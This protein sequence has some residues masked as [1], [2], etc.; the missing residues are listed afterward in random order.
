[1]TYSSVNLHFASI[2]HWRQTATEL[3]CLLQP[4]CHVADNTQSFIS[5]LH[6][7]KWKI[8]LN[9]FNV[10]PKHI[11]IKYILKVMLFCSKSN[12]FM[13][14]QH[15]G[16][17]VLWLFKSFQHHPAPACTNIT[18]WKTNYIT[19]QL[20]GSLCLWGDEQH[21]CTP[22]NYTGAISVY[23]LHQNCILSSLVKADTQH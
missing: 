5:S 13:A 16:S 20:L 15:C 6:L 19:G 22:R 8:I 9:T 1:M 17:P 3:L 2:C 4:G 23:T 7:L 14:E 12:V 21:W 18:D 10:V 11:R